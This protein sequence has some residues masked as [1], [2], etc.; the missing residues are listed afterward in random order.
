M[1]RTL[2]A[3][4]CLGVDISFFFFLI[5]LCLLPWPPHV[6]NEVPWRS[7]WPIIECSLPVPSIGIVVYS[8]YF[9]VLCLETIYVI[10][11]SYISRPNQTLRIQDWKAVLILICFLDISGSIPVG[12]APESSP[13]L[14]TVNFA[15]LILTARTVLWQTSAGTS[16]LIRGETAGHRQ[17]TTRGWQPHLHLLP[18][19]FYCISSLRSIMIL[20][21]MTPFLYLSKG[22]AER[23]CLF[24]KLLL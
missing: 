4:G 5:Q 11:V 1:Q 13:F 8:H 3:A 6:G 20:V 12:A 17:Q 14:P 18:A 15:A 9:G 10:M 16:C 19:L 23:N 24:L 22:F 21:R 7:A 2:A